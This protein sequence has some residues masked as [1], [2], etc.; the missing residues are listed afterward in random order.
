[1]NSKLYIVA[2]FAA[3]IA[4]MLASACKRQPKPIPLPRDALVLRFESAALKESAEEAIEIPGGA[5]VRW[6]VAMPRTLE[7]G[8]AGTG[9]ELSRE[10]TGRL[11]DA[12]RARE[13]VLVAR[14]KGDL[15]EEMTFLDA[16][17]ATR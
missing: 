14:I 8:L 9:I 5:E 11:I 7:T 13:D 10:D 4:L 2:L 17:F 16:R 6:L 15:L 1:M 12:N 3:L